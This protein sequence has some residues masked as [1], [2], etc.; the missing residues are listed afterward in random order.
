MK[1]SLPRV[2]RTK[3]RG[4]PRPG[5]TL[6]RYKLGYETWLFPVS[7]VPAHWPVNGY[8]FVYEFKI[9]KVASM[10]NESDNEIEVFV[11]RDVDGFNLKLVSSSDQSHMERD[12]AVQLLGERGVLTR[13]VCQELHESNEEF[14]GRRPRIALSFLLQWIVKTQKEFVQIEPQCADGL[15]NMI[16]PEGCE[17]LLAEIRDGVKVGE[18]FFMLLTA[19]TQTEQRGDEEV[20]RER[21]AE[22]YAKHRSPVRAMNSIE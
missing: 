17:E 11:Y 12:S 7:P 18:A 16:I 2:R 8:H 5:K 4:F 19:D 21:L 13:L 1:S 20:L 14:A 9:A 6:T 3:C 10:T 22:Y 15:D